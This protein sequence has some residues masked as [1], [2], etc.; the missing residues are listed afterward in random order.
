[1]SKIVSFQQLYEYFVSN[2]CDVKFHANNEN[3]N[4]DISVPGSLQFDSQDRTDETEGLFPV[5]LQACHILKND[6]QS[7]I[8]EDSMNNALSSFSNRP[9]LGYIHEVDGVPQF[10]THNMHINEDEE[11]VY[12]EIP[13][14]VIPESCNARL[15]YDSDKKQTYCCVEGYIYE[16]Y[17]KAAEIIQREG[18]CPVSVELSVREMS[19]NAKDKILNLED[20]YFSGVTILGYDESGKAIKPGMAGSN[21]KINNAANENISF[22]QNDKLIE[23]LE[24]LNKTLEE[25]KINN[26]ERK[27]EKPMD[28]FNELLEK[29]NKTVEDVTFDYEGLSDEEL[30][31]AFAEAFAEQD[32]NSGQ[33]DP[34]VQQFDDAD[35]DADPDADGLDDA[36]DE[37]EDADQGAADDVT[38]MIEALPENPDANDQYTVQAARDAYNGLTDTQKELVEATTVSALEDAEE[39]VAADKDAIAKRDAGDEPATRRNNELTYSVVIDG[40]VKQFSVSLTEKL[41]A[42]RDL[43]NHTY[44][45]SDNTWYDVDAYDDEKYVV[46]HDYWNNKHYRQNYSVKK[47]VYSL[48]GDRVEVFARFLT[49]DEINNLDS[50]KSNYEQIS[51]DL[52]QYQKKELVNSNDYSAIADKEDF[53]SVVNDVNNGK[54]EMTF[55][56]LKENL[57]KML[58][59]YAKS[60]SLNFEAVEDK[61]KE[62]EDK[63]PSKKFTKVGLVPAGAKGNPKKSRY[64]NIFKKR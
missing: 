7:F 39:A 48:K 37:D 15:E 13:V 5:T 57:D 56:E 61:A 1:M 59:N 45:E 32:D 20:F 64:G 19:Y 52:A 27:E 36:E 25:L 11:L 35:P 23:T 18:Q 47:D 24:N 33:A 29:Y 40:T 53:V 30:E 6:N 28:K 26:A 44:S 50:M 41:N 55:E 42:L 31:T 3:N 21:I 60:G 22:E 62:A 38:A 49:Q 2:K 17:S 14:G 34:E 9:I 12:D 46:M 16:E 51:N 58:L 63:K 10:Y 8:S 4:I 43:V 54:N